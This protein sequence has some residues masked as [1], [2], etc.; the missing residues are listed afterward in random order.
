M[1]GQ[2]VCSQGGRDRGNYYLILEVIDD[3]FV[4]LVDGDKRR[5]EN[6]KLKNVKHLQFFTA[7][8]EELA[9]QWEAG[10]PVGNTEVR[11]MIAALRPTQPGKESE[12]RG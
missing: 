11:K 12:T 3:N 10:Q 7:V 2:L 4:Y 1:I 8:A 6:P 9:M 5:M